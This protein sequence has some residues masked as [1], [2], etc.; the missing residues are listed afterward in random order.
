M[1]RLG[2]TP[3]TTGL[4]PWF[5]RGT[6]ALFG[7]LERRH[8]GAESL[9]PS[10][11]SSPRPMNVAVSGHDAVL[12]R[13]D[14]ANA[15]D[16][17]LR[18]AARASAPMVP[19]GASLRALLS[20][21]AKA[22]GGPTLSE[23]PCGSQRRTFG[24]GR[25]VQVG[26]FGHGPWDIPS[27]VNQWV[28]PSGVA[29]RDRLRHLATRTELAGFPSVLRGQRSSERARPSWKPGAFRGVTEPAGE[30][31]TGRL[32]CKDGRALRDPAQ[33]SPRPDVE[34]CPTPVVVLKQPTPPQCIPFGGC[35]H[36]RVF[37][38][39][40][41]GFPA[42]RHLRVPPAGGHGPSLRART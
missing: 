2:S 3:T 39:G 23:S 42:P 16:G 9:A 37:I 32:H 33:S 19:F 27:G 7:T 10:G 5:A 26:A 17:V 22:C 12:L 4:F 25:L 6:R 21:R 29:Q 28:A 30:A 8:C 11:T 18:D 13:K 15:N 1:H 41:C 40:C 35:R 24:C 34:C 38:F 31:P 36:L 14:R 20:G